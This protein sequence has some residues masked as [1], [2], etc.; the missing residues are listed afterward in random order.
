MSEYEAEDIEQSTHPAVTVAPHLSKDVGVVIVGPDGQEQFHSILPAQTAIP[1]RRSA[2]LLAPR[3]GGDVVVKFV[4]GASEIQRHIPEKPARKAPNGDAG[5]GNDDG[6]D[7]DDD[8]DDEEEEEEEVKTKHMKIE[9]L[10]AETLLKG[11]EKGQR[12]EVTIQ[13]AAD[14]ALHIAARIVGTQQGLR[15]TVLAPA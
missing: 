15:G 8:D 10:L 7:D 13:A 3:D 14:G 9:K 4:E 6:D 2:E 12:I 1:A 5:D 11:V